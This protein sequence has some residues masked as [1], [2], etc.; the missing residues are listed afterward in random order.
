MELTELI[1][2]IYSI[3]IEENID[4]L[5][6]SKCANIISLLLRFEE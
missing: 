6:Q 2:W 5:I 1:Q 4:L 3:L